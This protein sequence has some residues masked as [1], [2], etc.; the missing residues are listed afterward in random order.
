MDST[1]SSDAEL[2]FYSAISLLRLDGYSL[3][4]AYKDFASLRAT[5]EMR[6]K[7]ITARV[8]TGFK[9]APQDVVNGLAIHLL[10]RLSRR[11]AGADYYVSAYKEFMKRESTAKLD[12]AMRRTRAR[13]MHAHGKAYDLNDV[14]ARVRKDYA[15]IV[16]ST[17]V[18]GIGWS[19]RLGRRVLGV[20]DEAH[21]V[22]AIN[23]RLDDGDVPFF[24][25][26]YLVYHELL[27]AKHGA[28]Y[29]RG[30]T[31][32]RRVHTAPFREDEKRFRYYAEADHWIR[33]KWQLLDSY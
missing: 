15:E 30:A 22:I 16:G 8:S 32:Q 7:T 23:S 20:H 19:Q 28:Q 21:N 4:F 27:H 3:D 33:T 14:L 12:G 25:V 10:Q 2:A 13:I 31:K 24:V 6:G 1:E 18:A 5:V 26:D 17:A 29:E 9:A 11:D